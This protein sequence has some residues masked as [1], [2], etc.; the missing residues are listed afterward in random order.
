MGLLMSCPGP[1]SG[2]AATACD[3]RDSIAG[4]LAPPFFDFISAFGFS[5]FDVGVT[6]T[7]QQG[8]H[9]A[10]PTQM[11]LKAFPLIE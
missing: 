10:S 7:Q 5:G 4:H 8:K 2:A 1:A 3:A 11:A 6:V 9:E